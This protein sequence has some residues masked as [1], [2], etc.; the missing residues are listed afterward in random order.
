VPSQLPPYAVAVAGSL[1]PADGIDPGPGDGVYSQPI[2][3]GASKL[4]CNPFQMG[5]GGHEPLDRALVIDLYDRWLRASSVPAGEMCLGDGRPVPPD[6]AAAGPLRS[7]TG[8]RVDEALRSLFE[9][10]QAQAIHAVRFECSSSCRLGAPCHGSVLARRMRQLVPVWTVGRKTAPRRL[11]DT[12][13]L[14]RYVRSRTDEFASTLHCM[15]AASERLEAAAEERRAAREG[16]T[17]SALRARERQTRAAERAEAA[18]RSREERLAKSRA[19]GKR[20]RGE[21]RASAPGPPPP[22]RDVL[23]AAQQGDV[24][25]LL[26]GWAL[27]VPNAYAC[28]SRDAA[29]TRSSP[30]KAGWGARWALSTTYVLADFVGIYGTGRSTTLLVQPRPFVTRPVYDKG[31]DRYVATSYESDQMEMSVADVEGRTRHGPAQL[32]VRMVPTAGLEDEEEGERR[33]V[34]REEVDELER[35]EERHASRCLDFGKP[36]RRYPSGGAAGDAAACSSSADSDSESEEETSRGE[37]AQAPVKAA[38]RRQAAAPRV[39][40]TIMG[41]QPAQELKMAR[42]AHEP[43]PDDLQRAAQAHG[44]GAAGDGGQTAARKRRGARPS[45]SARRKLQ[46]VETAAQRETEQRGSQ[47]GGTLES[48]LRSASGKVPPPQ[49]EETSE[50]RRL[51]ARLRA[52]I[53]ARDVACALLKGSGDWPGRGW[54]LRR[55]NMAYDVAWGHSWRSLGQPRFAPETLEGHVH[56]AEVRLEAERQRIRRCGESACESGEGRGVGD[57]TGSG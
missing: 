12:E 32:T 22:A 7:L 38:K 13:D 44:G 49:R 57:G 51:L 20:Q 10:T 34:S 1:D 14:A 42:P 50:A 46:R 48:S 27:Y 41:T 15:A 9:T 29:A 47:E 2:T 56:N 30:A 19:V 55:V 23:R 39:L 36:Q 6:V 54:V 31:S 45:H 16:L 11:T 52:A 3:R 53:A 17:A 8:A 33:Q 18:A 35:R 26:S 40:H 24:E 25:G 37:S 28:R 43:R 5:E 21:K 4:F